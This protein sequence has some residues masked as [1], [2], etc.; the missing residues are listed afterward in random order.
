[1]PEPNLARNVRKPSTV[2]P[3]SRWNLPPPLLLLVLLLVI[4]LVSFGSYTIYQ[5]QESRIVTEHFEDLRFIAQFKVEQIQQW[6]HERFLDAEFFSSSPL[7][8]QG[9]SSWIQSGMQ[10]EIPESVVDRIENLRQI[11]DYDSILITTL[12]GE[13]VYPARTST[14]V[15][16]EQILALIEQTLLTAK[17][18][19]GD[20]YESP[21]AEKILLDF[22]SPI[23]SGQGKIVAVLVL[24]V[25][26]ESYL[27]PM[28]QDWPTTSPS[29]ETLLVRQVGESVLFL[30]TLRHSDAAPLTLRLPLNQVTT[31]AVQAVQGLE[32]PIVGTD[33]RGVEVYAQTM[34]LTGTPWYMVSK[35]D[36]VE[37]RSEVRQILFG[38]L[39]IDGMALVLALVAGAYT[40]SQ[41]QK[42]LYQKV[43][44]VEREA[45]IEHHLLSETLRAS[46]D[47]IYL[48]DTV[49]YRFRFINDGALKNLGYHQDQMLYMTPL[50]IKPAISEK[51]FARLLQPLLDGKQS[52]VV[53]ETIH[54]RADHSTYPV[55]AHVQ[56]VD[57]GNDKVYLAVIQ[58][59][60]ERKQAAQ[61]VKESYEK[62]Q[63]LFQTFPHGLMVTDSER[64]IAE[65]NAAT[66]EILKLTS[67]EILGR[68]YRNLPW[69]LI[70]RQGDPL[71]VEQMASTRAMVENQPV[72]N[73]V[74]GVVTKSNETTWVKVS[75]IPIPL[76]QYGALLILE[77]ISNQIKLESELQQSRQRYYY[78]VELSP[79]AIYVI[80]DGCI[81]FI[82]PAGVS[83]F[84]ASSA[85]EIIG[86]SSMDFFSS[87]Y[88][89]AFQD[90]IEKMRTENQPTPLLSEK[91][92]R[93]DGELRDVEVT[94]SPFF[95]EQGFAIQVILRDI[96][97]RRL[98]EENLKTQLN[99]LARWHEATLGREARILELKEEVNQSLREANLPPRYQTYS[100]EA[101]TNRGLDE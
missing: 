42:S 48:F 71:P 54:Q 52:L 9:I 34:A 65:V 5:A 18:T 46:L 11:H 97:E 14:P 78:L 59:I 40:V 58:D 93:L 64:V 60:S 29:G 85:D 37:V 76:P 75:A 101:K 61:K 91:I 66:E 36:A 31:P 38:L 39:V 7:F 84:A 82:N 16:D 23:R 30:N 6:Q 27:F 43:L 12:T 79:E 22:A 87:E 80:R 69:R 98:A 88:H 83:L 86:R 51:E 100:A 45:Q 26:P 53:F 62:Y 55:E 47:E 10:V 49:T 96:T 67:R 28:I 19:M 50:D 63:V 56:L 20:L 2:I 33:Y 73:V 57:Y 25:D 90:L 72:M 24:R 92:I 21:L 17:P 94:A 99:E 44:H 74:M 89:A 81:E 32:G 77:D 1:M 3:S 8:Q 41:R 68:S 13:L 35:I 15:P 4:L 95:D 70:D